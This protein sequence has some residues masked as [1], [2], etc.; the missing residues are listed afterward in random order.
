MQSRPGDAP[1]EDGPSA[2]AVAKLSELS[3][4]TITRTGVYL[5]PRRSVGS[6]ISQPRDAFK[7]WHPETASAA[8]PC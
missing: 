1:Q 6:Q 7:A 3:L 2:T 8:R 5:F 4:E